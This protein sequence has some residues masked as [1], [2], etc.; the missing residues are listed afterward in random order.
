VPALRQVQQIAEIATRC[1]W[2][3]QHPGWMIFTLGNQHFQTMD[4]ILKVR[5]LLFFGTET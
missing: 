3:P 2:E 1:W 5:S 4:H